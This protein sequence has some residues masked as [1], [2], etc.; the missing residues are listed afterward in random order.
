MS[1]DPDI[2][3]LR[4]DQPGSD[5][6]VELRNGRFLDVIGGRYLD[7]GTSLMIE[8]GRIRSL[9]GR[10]SELAIRSGLQL[11]PAGAGGIGGAG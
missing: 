10:P 5:A 1:G 3:F 11:E 6:R 4:G 2:G 8:A 7:P 9:S